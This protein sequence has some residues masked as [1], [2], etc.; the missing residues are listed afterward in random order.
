MRGRMVAFAL[1]FAVRRRQNSFRVIFSVSATSRSPNW[2]LSAA[3]HF[4][5]LAGNASAGATHPSPGPSNKRRQWAEDTMLKALR[6]RDTLPRGAITD[7]ALAK[8][9]KLPYN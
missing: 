6:I 1:C 5:D 2:T 7:Y 9:H 4:R 8:Q 3:A